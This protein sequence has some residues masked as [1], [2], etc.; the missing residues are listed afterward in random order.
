M[1]P[2]MYGSRQS[3]VL[4]LGQFPIPLGLRGVQNHSSLTDRPQCAS[5]H[6]QVQLF[7]TSGCH[8]QHTTPSRAQRP[9]APV[10]VL[11][12]SDMGQGFGSLGDGCPLRHSSQ[13]SLRETWPVL[14]FQDSLSSLRP[15]KDTHL[16]LD[17]VGHQQRDLRPRDH[18]TTQ[19]S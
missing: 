16:P 15:G 2:G 10:P 4:C 11:S 12:A 6:G 1:P 13:V 14:F 18:G 9:H 17:P 3:L 8:S 19:V 5:Q 7:P